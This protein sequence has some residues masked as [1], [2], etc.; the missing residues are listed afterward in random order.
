MAT[1]L[2]DGSIDV[3]WSAS[4]DNVGVAYYRVTRN[5]AEVVLVECTGD[6]G[7]GDHAR[8]GHALP[9]GASLRRCGELVVEDADGHRGDPRRLDD[10][11]ASIDGASDLATHDLAINDLATHDLDADA[12]GRHLEPVDAA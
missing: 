8:S 9:G 2:P 5:N 12:G 6:V 7:E 10:H 4:R 3:S 11:D 1:V